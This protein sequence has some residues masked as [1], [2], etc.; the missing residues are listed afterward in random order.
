MNNKQSK[1]FEPVTELKGVGAKTATALA[2]LGINT[3]YDLL[4][5]FPFRYDDLETIPLDQI[6][7]G[8]KVLLKGMVVT[9]PF[10]SRFGYRKT[11]LSFKMKIDHDIIMVNFFNQPWLKDKVES[12][13]EVAVY[14][15]Y[16]VARQ[17]LSGFKLVAEK[18]DS[19][20]A[21]I[22]SV[23]R[24]LKQNKL[25]KLIDLALEEA[26]NEVGE[27][28]PASIREKYRLLS[29]R[30]LVEKMHHPKNDNEAKIARRSAIF[31]EFFLFQMQLAQLLS[32]RNEDAPG[33]EKKYDL[34]AVKELIEEIPFELSDDQKKVVNE[35]FADLHSKRQ[36][37]RLLQGDVGSGK[38]VVAV[39]AIY[40][41]VTA[42]YQA[43][44]MVPT[45]ILA[46]QHFA[47]IDELLKPLGVRVAY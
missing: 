47:K 27:T 10:V 13:K 44:L 5:Y 17:S 23:N 40:A 15:K 14:G 21:P 8:Q 24:H 7:D 19:G 43:A 3:I 33:V 2:S 36:M 12:G 18:K 16:Q 39:F 4:F 26:I 32:Q 1:L 28:I 37:R 20:F 30:V 45:E 29:D 41:A 42:G 31:R 35:I 38:T 9:D 46:Q 25:Q 6:E 34:A 11:R 22:Y